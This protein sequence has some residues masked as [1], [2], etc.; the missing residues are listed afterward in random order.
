[1]LIERSGRPMIFESFD[2]EGPL[3]IKPTRHGDQRGFFSETY[4]KDAFTAAVG[5]VEFVQDNHSWSAD[6]GTLRGLHLQRPPAAQAKLVRVIRG[7]VLDVVVDVRQDAPTYGRHVAAELSADNGFQMWI[8][9]GFLH[10]FCTLTPDVEFLYKV[11]AYYEPALDCAVAFD[12]PDFGIQWPFRRDQLIISPKDASAP[13][14]HDIP[15][16]F[17]RG[18]NDRPG[19]GGEG[20]DAL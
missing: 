3:L 9:R 11:D 8:P 5:S 1:M 12:D 18:W 4:R 14:L 7:A 17:P 15:P 16:P 2:I 20:G 19:P 6:K 10:G 13:R